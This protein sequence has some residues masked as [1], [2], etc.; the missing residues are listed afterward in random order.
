VTCR[1]EGAEDLGATL[2]EGGSSVRGWAGLIVHR[3]SGQVWSGRSMPEGHCRVLGVPK[4]T[5]GPWPLWGW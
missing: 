1:K 3:C 4:G 2:G 5:W